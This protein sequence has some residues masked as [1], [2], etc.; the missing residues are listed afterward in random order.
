[1]TRS[2]YAEKFAA[3]DLNPREK[4]EVASLLLAVPQLSTLDTEALYLEEDRLLRLQK[5]WVPTLPEEYAKPFNEQIIAWVNDI[6]R[7]V[8]NRYRNSLKAEA[9]RYMPRPP[10]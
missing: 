9:L 8:D 6:R 4:Q 10:F 1:M 7:Q 3:L 2:F 5:E